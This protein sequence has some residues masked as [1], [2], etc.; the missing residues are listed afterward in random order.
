MCNKVYLDEK[1]QRA[2]FPNNPMS[3]FLI[4]QIE[5]CVIA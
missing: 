5:V 4:G 1:I 2:V 3:A